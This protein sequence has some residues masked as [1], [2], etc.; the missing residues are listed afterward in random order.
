MNT[1]DLSCLELRETV[2]LP[3]RTIIA[4]LSVIRE[5][6]L[7]LGEVKLD[8]RVGVGE[9]VLI[10]SD[11]FAAFSAWQAQTYGEPADQDADADLSQW[12]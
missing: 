4:P 6:R 10:S 11:L 1:P 5:I 7:V 8:L 2:N 3:A 9:T 12:N